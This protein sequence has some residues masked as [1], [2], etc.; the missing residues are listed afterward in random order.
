MFYFQSLSLFQT[1]SRQL[2]LRGV[3]SLSTARS[4]YSFLGLSLCLLLNST[5]ILP[6]HAKKGSKGKQKS[7]EVAAPLTE[8]IFPNLTVEEKTA[9]SEVR[10]DPHP[11]EIVRN[12][13][14][15]VSNEHNH[16]VW[17][18]Y[19]DQIGG[20]FIG[21][22]TDQNFLLAGWARPQLLIL[23]D[24]DGMIPVLHEIYEYFFTISASPEDFVKRWHKHYATDSTTLLKA[25]F[26]QQIQ[27]KQVE[28]KLSASKAKR[29]VRSR[30]KVYKTIRALIYRRLQRVIKKYK[31]LKIKTF[32]NDQEQYD[33]IRALWAQGRVIYIRGDLTADLTMLDLAQVLK[34][35]NLSLNVLYVSNAEQYFKITPQYRRNLLA[36]PWGEKSA[37]LRT[38]GWRILGFMNEDEK[39]HYN[40]QTGSNLSYWMKNVRVS[41]AGRMILRKKTKTSIAGYTLLDQDPKPSKKPPKVAE[42]P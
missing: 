32:L 9:L 5:L 24:F 6:V 2:N 21:V 10:S 42:L 30:M 20:A 13:H 39:Y 3:S 37:L 16:Q 11:D 28:L 1:I 29:W 36:L 33:F 25:Y 40:L 23:M 12:S 31:K 35:M 18:S 27:M 41:K 8:F 15:W 38:M 14:Y 26:D 4:R 34:K 22:G 17:K 7:L 19:I